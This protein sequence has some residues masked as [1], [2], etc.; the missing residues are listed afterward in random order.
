MATATVEAAYFAIRCKV[1][2][3]SR[4]FAL[5]SPRV[6]LSQH[7]MVLPFKVL[8]NL[9]GQVKGRS[10]CNSR[11]GNT[12]TLALSTTDAAHEIVTNI[13]V[14]GMRKAKHRHDDISH[15]LGVLIP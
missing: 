11:F 3:N 13:G 12:D 9:L 5:S 2:Q 4:A 14:D 10:M 8:K 7:W 6:L 15:V 1:L